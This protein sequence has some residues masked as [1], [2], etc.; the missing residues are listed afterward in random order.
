MDNVQKAY[1]YINIPLSHFRSYG[2]CKLMYYRPTE[3]LLKEQQEGNEMYIMW[4]LLV[5]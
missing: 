1:N 3:F 4:D 5:N 2:K